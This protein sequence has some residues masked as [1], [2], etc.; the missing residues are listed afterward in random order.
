MRARYSAAVL[1]SCMWALGCTPPTHLLLRSRCP[2]GGADCNETKPPEPADCKDTSDCADGEDCFKGVCIA[3]ATLLDTCSSCP[4]DTE[5]YKVIT[6]ACVTC[7]CRPLCKLHSDCGQGMICAAG[8]CV[9]C[10]SASCPTT[11]SW[12]FAPQTVMH[13]GCY[14]CECA[15]KSQCES[16]AACGAGMICYPGAQCDDGCAD[17]K[18]C[19]GN[20]CGAPG[21]KPLAEAISCTAVGCAAG[22]CRGDVGCVATGCK[23]DPSAAAANPYGWVCAQTCEGGPRCESLR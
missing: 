12:G 20:L 10:K 4:A 13:N 17:P 22:E 21:C 18:C 16:D 23:C 3:C 8:S 11:C 15:P 9:D 5:P 1:A 19:K 6:G 7:E 14:V 2:D